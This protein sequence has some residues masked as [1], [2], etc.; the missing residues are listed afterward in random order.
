[1][2]YFGGSARANPVPAFGGYLGSVDSSTGEQ[3]HQST[4]SVV[5][6]TEGMWAPHPVHDLW[7]Q[8]PQIAALHIMNWE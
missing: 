7:W 5:S 4:L 3:V 8:I 1:M 2:S 6:I